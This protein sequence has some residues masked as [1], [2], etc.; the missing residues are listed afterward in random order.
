MLLKLHS[1]IWCCMLIVCMKNAASDK[2]FNNIS[3]PKPKLHQIS[4]DLMKSIIAGKKKNE[5]LLA[6]K[7]LLKSSALHSGNF[8]LMLFEM[9]TRHE[10][11]NISKYLKQIGWELLNMALGSVHV[12]IIQQLVSRRSRH[13]RVE[14]YLSRSDKSFGLSFNPLTKLQQFARLPVEKL[15]T[16]SSQ[17]RKRKKVLS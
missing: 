15:K 17:K 9:K 5:K 4:Y 1:P 2:F 7:Y 10:G 3:S 8:L 13:K 16:V 11:I 6:G 14:K 12:L